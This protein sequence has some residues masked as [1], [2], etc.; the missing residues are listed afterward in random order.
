MWAVESPTRPP[1]K[2]RKLLYPNDVP[3]L[4][5]PKRSLAQGFSLKG[6]CK[7]GIHKLQMFGREKY[8]VCFQTSS[9]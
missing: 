5:R 3:G 2:D 6:P 7:R 1:L 9:A 8:N 4:E